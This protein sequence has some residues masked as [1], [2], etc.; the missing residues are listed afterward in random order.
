MTQWL[1]DV[2]AREENSACP[3]C[4]HP[5]VVWEWLAVH[6]GPEHC[7]WSLTHVL[8]SAVLLL[9]LGEMKC[10]CRFFAN[11]KLL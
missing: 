3:V 7:F 8:C 9:E 6:E 5:L 4:D 1:Q 2:E 10:V 11:S